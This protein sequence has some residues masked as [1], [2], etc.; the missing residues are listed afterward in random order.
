MNFN[1]AIVQMDLEGNEIQRFPNT[2][3]A[4]RKLGVSEKLII[5]NIK[6]EAKTVQD[7]W[8]FDFPIPE[9]SEKG[10]QIIANLEPLGPPEINEALMNYVPPVEDPDRW[11]T[12]FERILKRRPGGSND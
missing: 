8:L 5:K 2:K 4:A 1:S 6:G 3:T 11:L 12:P 9:L 10:K 7:K